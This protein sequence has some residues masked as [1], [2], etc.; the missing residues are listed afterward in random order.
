MT[1]FNICKGITFSKNINGWTEH[2]DM[3]IFAQ[4]ADINMTKWSEGLALLI[5]QK[6]NIENTI[7]YEYAATELSPI[8]VD[9][10][11]TEDGFLSILKNI[12]TILGIQ[13]FLHR[14]KISLGIL[15][16]HRIFIDEKSNL[17]IIG[18]HLVRPWS[19]APNL[20]ML[21]KDDLAYIPP[22]YSDRIDSQPDHRSDLYSLGVLFYYWLTGQVPFSGND[23]LA[24]IHKHL[25]KQPEKVSTWNEDVPMVLEN[26]ISI[27]LEKNPG[28]RYQSADGLLLDIEQLLVEP[29]R[30]SDTAFNFNENYNPGVFQIKN[31]LY[32]REQEIHSLEKSYSEA[33]NGQPQLILLGGYSGVGKTALV[34]FCQDK[35]QMD[36][37]FF[38][39]GK[40]DQFQNTPYS[41]FI[42]AFEQL[43]QQLLFLPEAEMEIWRNKILAAVGENAGVLA[44]VI[45]NLELLLGQQPT[46]EVLNPVETQNR[47]TFVFLQF[48]RLFATE[49][50]PLVL[51]IDDWQWSDMPSLQLLK[52]L[53]QEGLP[54]LFFIAAYRDNEVGEGHPFTLLLN[55]L[56]NAPITRQRLKLQD[57][58]E[59]CINQLIAE[60]IGESTEKIKPFSKIIFQKTNGNAFFTRQFLQSLWE[61][62]LL[63]FDFNEKK[64]N[65]DETKIKAE[66]VSENVIELLT[67]KI[68]QLPEDTQRLLKIAAFTGADFD[69]E[70]IAAVSSIEIKKCH[71][72][73]S[74][75]EHSGLIS[76]IKNNEK[77][78]SFLH[79]RIQQASYST[80]LIGQYQD[81][82]EL[83]Y[84]IGKCLV[85][86]KEFDHFQ[87]NEK[88]VHFLRSINLV[89]ENL[90]GKIIDLFVEAGNRAK[91][92]NSPDAAFEYF[93]AAKKLLD[94]NREKELLILTGQMESAFLLNRVEEAGAFAVAAIEVAEGAVEKSKIYVLQ[95]LFYESL[96]LFEKNIRCGVQALA[97]FDI[98][99]KAAM[100][101]ALLESRVQDEYFQL[102][103]ILGDRQP[104]DFLDMPRLEDEQEAAL[105]DVL[106]NM[107][108]SAYFADLF[109]FAW[110]CLRMG[111]QTLRHGKAH[112]TPFAFNFLGSL[113]VALYREFDL[114]Y[115]FGKTGIDMQRQLDSQQYLCRTLSIFSIFIQHFKEPIL[116]SIP[117]LRE[118]VH[119]GLET[120]DL[121]YAGYSMYAQVR[122]G[123]LAAP[124]LSGVLETCETSI[125]FMQKVQNPGL[126]ALM[127]LFR[128]NLRLLTGEYDEET[129]QEEK[130]SLDFL[131]EIMFYTAVAHHYI[132]KSWALCVLGR[133]EEALTYL[134]KN[135]SILIY[136]SSQ[137]HVPKHYFLQSLALLKSKE[138]LSDEESKLIISNQQTLK[139][140]ADSMPQNF[141]PEYRLIEALLKSKTEKLSEA[142]DELDM[143]IGWSKAGGLKGM[144]AMAY[145][146]GMHIFHQQN[147]PA[148]TDTYEREA[149]RNYVQWGALEK[150][151][152]FE[153]EERKPEVAG[154]PSLPVLDYDTRSLLKATQSISAEVSK[155]AL[156]KSLLQIVLENAGA[157]KAVLLLQ[158]EKGLFVEAEMNLTDSSFLAGKKIFVEESESVP[159]HC[160]GF[161]AKSGKEMV[162][163]QPA[164]FAK[165]NDDYFI[166]T[167]AKSVLALPLQRQQEMVGILYL[168]NNQMSGIFQEDRLPVLR[169]IAAQAAISLTN[170][171]LYEQSVRLNEELT[172]SRSELS[173]M[174]ELLEER[175]RDRT[176]VLREEVEM[177]KQAETELTVAK[178]AADQANQAKSQFLANM[179]HEIRSPLNAIVGFSQILLNQSRKLELS[180]DFRKYLSNIMVSGQHLSELI[181]D[182]LDLS[183]IEAG[184]MTL[185]EEDLNLKQ[186]VQSLY[187]LQKATAKEKGIEL[188]YDFDPATPQFIC[189]DRS[190]LKQILLN[191]M[192]NAIK[193]T[194]AGKNIFLRAGFTKNHILLEVQD[195]GIGI[196]LDKQAT[197]FDP[198]VQ[199]DASVT[200]EFGGTGLGLAITKNM[201]EM[202]GGEI[203]LESTLGEGSTFK[204]A[205][206]YHPPQR[207]NIGQ[208]EIEL[209]KISIPQ[210]TCILVV[211][212]NPMNQE[213]IK[214]YFRE[215]NHDILLAEDGL[216][217]IEMAS[218]YQPDLIFMDI[219]MPG[220]DGFEAMHRIRQSDK[221]TPIVALS[222]DAFKEQ[223]EKALEAG[224]ND[225]LTKPIQVNQLLEC[226]QVHLLKEKQVDASSEKELTEE[227]KMKL[228]SV[229]DKLSQTPIYET[230]KLVGLVEGLNDLIASNMQEQMMEIIYAADTE[231]FEKL[232]TH[233]KNK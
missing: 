52:I 138:K 86:Q 55:E 99:I 125:A 95:M 150:V 16:H 73:L 101:N 70:L 46:P 203:T 190:K 26:I 81:D 3:N 25:T 117:V 15:A 49:E 133:Y 67:G 68:K 104:K 88:A 201:V 63:A 161:V 175:I 64:W 154:K 211:E 108:A 96:A 177:R 132:F 152:L 50:K 77:K 136:A 8:N 121:P 111:N 47:F 168:Q 204:V 97:L 28:H 145:E 162:L 60:A 20:L 4:S 58:E 189:S 198:F 151:K 174:N 94:N 1:A 171:Q 158:E 227:E 40:F 100:E 114:G 230:E 179:S 38:L 45:P 83:H 116:N 17:K 184:K 202:L 223:Q 224:F 208:T 56:N 59:K 5:P 139:A 142:L 78:Y 191:L 169:A 11:K 219:H 147:M 93:S 14:Q 76:I 148:L 32:G 185:S 82:T 165:V 166:K 197:I 160:I 220:M 200:R 107:C 13:S 146:I 72:L 231:G 103:E 24:V 110:C 39:Q 106:V 176:R 41:P 205:I 140:W 91:N 225:Y 113:L 182:I 84:L 153:K 69:V 75:A 206:P 226:L 27:L 80:N 159:K 130:E 65:W 31:K 12:K 199:A 209:D 48:I 192:S 10:P 123:F 173:K 156:V 79:D 212:D 44:E 143:A 228:Q 92:S 51:F 193:F 119:S 62:E 35:W 215:L 122:D 144:E 98:D 120:G 53:A 172:S 137:S 33:K 213:M 135:Q 180:N 186:L 183:K 170:A 115:A 155:E 118:S 210:N 214:A 196:E 178:N 85:T 90:K 221:E 163:N 36:N 18:F 127:K 89:E 23:G 149:Q 71:D 128:A 229:L 141:E 207:I 22:E 233:L 232:I 157:E 87:P 19:E 61:R 126:L 218:R 37:A 217:G 129:T 34:Q 66:N 181:N 2:A 43:V 29:E 54:Y 74:E 194:P 134:D 167:S 7:N 222:A 109:L 30:M 6:I 124:N 216:T 9:L 42:S 164:H 195:E 102:K 57:L 112:S 105:L 188:R 21:S 131:N 187:H